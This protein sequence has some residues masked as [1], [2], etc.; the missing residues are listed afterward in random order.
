MYVVHGSG[1]LIVKLGIP[2]N[3]HGEVKLVIVVQDGFGLQ[4]NVIAH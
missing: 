4:V 2:L 3:H 1:R